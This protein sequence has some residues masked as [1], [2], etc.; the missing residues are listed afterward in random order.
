MIF[1]TLCVRL[2]TRSLFSS[3]GSYSCF[4]GQPG[5]RYLGQVVMVAQCV[6]DL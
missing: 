1:P 5:L 2:E 6:G 3:G 4:G